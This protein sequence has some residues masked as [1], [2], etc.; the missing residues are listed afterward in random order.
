M[1]ALPM[2]FRKVSATVGIISTVQNWGRALADH[3]GLT[4]RAY[5]CR[6]RNGL[7]FFIR[8]GTDDTRVLFEIFV[9]RCYRSAEVLDGATVIDVGANIGCFSIWASQTAARVLACEPHPDN[10]LMLRRN[11]DLNSVTNVTVIPQA[12]AS[13]SGTAAL[14]IPDE[15]SFVGRYSLQ[16]G[17]GSRTV[18]VTC[19]TLADVVNEAGLTAVDLLKIDCQGSEYDILYGSANVLP[20]VQQIIVECEE[21]PNQ[22]ERSA[23]ELARF[24]SDLGFEVQAQNNILYAKRF[25]SA[26]PL[27]AP[28]DLQ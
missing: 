21:F 8:A 27:R 3:L 19:T 7:S 6:L 16:P 15:E 22:P 24:L 11:M 25:S 5:V 23:N 18:E 10:L 4:R 13:E 17:R 28:K 20:L 12:L 1:M 14:V 9:R 26:H 2:L